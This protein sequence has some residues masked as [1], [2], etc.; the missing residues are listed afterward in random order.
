MKYSNTDH[1]LDEVSILWKKELH[2]NCSSFRH[3]F[4][5]KE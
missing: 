3:T 2:E 1:E 5:V 4:H